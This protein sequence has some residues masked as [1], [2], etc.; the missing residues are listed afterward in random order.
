M[1]VS[2]ESGRH[3]SPPRPLF[4]EDFGAEQLAAKQAPEIIAPIFTADDI[5]E[6]RTIAWAEGR[7]AALAEVELANNQAMKCLAQSI[8]QQIIDVGQAAQQQIEA[9]AEAMAHLLLDVLATLLPDLCASHGKAEARA[10]SKIVLGGLAQDPIVTVS[11]NPALAEC[12]IDEMASVVSGLAVRPKVISC[13]TIDPGD[14]RITWS[15]GAAVRDCR[16]MLSQV[17]SVLGL[18]GLQC[19]KINAEMRD[20]A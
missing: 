9:N 8:T 11:V 16:K 13:T 10:L 20:A 19:D 5:T 18:F 15:D 1:I 6:A 2:P 17:T 4:T 7:V 14:A 12:L 3:R